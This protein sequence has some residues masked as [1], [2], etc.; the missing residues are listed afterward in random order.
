MKKIK[1]LMFVVFILL[2][3]KVSAQE[4]YM[5]ERSTIELEILKNGKV[6]KIVGYLIAFDMQ[7]LKS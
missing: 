5:N 4:K 1:K 6:E 2:I 3:I 7:D